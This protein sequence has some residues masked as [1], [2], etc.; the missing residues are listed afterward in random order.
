MLGKLASGEL[1]LLVGTHALIE[2]DVEFRALAVAV[3]TSSTASACASARRS[4]SKGTP[5]ML[6]MTATPIPRTLA[7]AGYGD[8]DTST[9][10]E[11]PLGRQ[12]IDTRIVAGERG[13]RARL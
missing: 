9:L 11:L 7:L 4:T 8:L 2:P 10:R 13:A 1:S 3:S 5:H 12:P 6:H